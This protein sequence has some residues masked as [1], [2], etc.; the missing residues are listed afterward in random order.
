MTTPIEQL[1][2]WRSGHVYLLILLEAMDRRFVV[3]SSGFIK[4]LLRDEIVFDL[5]DSGDVRLRLFEKTTFTYLAADK[6]D[7]DVHEHI[8]SQITGAVKIEWPGFRLS[9]LEPRKQPTIT[10]PDGAT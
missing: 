8:T 10:Y 3:K 7:A 9:L 2:E 6:A 4:D 1:K 5:A